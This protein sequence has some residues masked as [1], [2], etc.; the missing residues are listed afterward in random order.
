MGLSIH[1]RVDQ[2]VGEREDGGQFADVLDQVTSGV[3]VRDVT[4]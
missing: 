4:I 1:P 3:D 2:V